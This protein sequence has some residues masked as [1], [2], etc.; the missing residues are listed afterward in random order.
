MLSIP[1]PVLA[2]LE[3]A[4][5]TAIAMD[6][7]TRQA[8]ARHS[9]AVLEV[10][11]EAPLLHFFVTPVPEGLLLRRQFDG[12]PDASLHASSFGLIRSS[13]NQADLEGVF[14][15]DVRIEGDV[16]L[17]GS[18]ARALRQLEPDW[19]EWL[20]SRLGDA[21]SFRIEQAWQ[22]GRQFFQRSGQGR[23]IEW[24][25][26]LQHE[27]NT[28]VCAEELGGFIDD[29]DR[30]RDDLDRLEARLQRLTPEPT[31]KKRGRGR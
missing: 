24:A 28:V 9:G 10:V 31:R 22:Q 15:K 13:M 7:K 4:L 20:A 17:A 2:V 27:S 1:T 3:K 11:I 23:L 5:N 21:A 18:V 19:P 16:E 30:L 8:L 6:P 25:D 14:S 29:T 26:F 12:A